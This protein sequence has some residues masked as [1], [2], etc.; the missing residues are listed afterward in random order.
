[1][2]KFAIISLILTLLIGI[3]ACNDELDPTA[4]W[5]N[6]PVVYGMLN[7]N[8]SVHYIKVNKAFLGDAPAAEMAAIS[9]SLFYDN[10][11]VYINQIE[12]GN[13]VKRLDFVP[14]DTIP[15]PEEDNP[16]EVEFATDRNT[17]YIYQGEIDAESNAGNDYTYELHVEIPDENTEC[18]SQLKLISGAY[19]ISPLSVQK[20]SLENYSFG[21]VSTEYRTGENGSLYQMVFRF[22]YLEVTDSGD[23]IKDLKPIEISWPVKTLSG[24]DQEV[25][26]DRS[27][28]QF[29]EELLI[30]VKEKEGVTR[31]VRYPNSATFSLYVADED[32]RIY[33]E[34]SEPSYGAVQEKPFFTNI[35]NGVGLFAARY[36]QER[37]I[38][39]TLS[40]VT[41]IATDTLTDQLNFADRDNPYYVSNR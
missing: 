2:K 25:S 28:E 15:K 18:T 14:V 21:S 24:A 12:S 7:Q 1:M 16:N 10:A 32:F 27:V 40:T 38:P 41:K 31:L 35:E 20:L 29:Y 22:Y 11:I 5:E 17:I 9:D 13:V 30:Q 36:T 8:D 3:S 6:I 39:V 26:L 33:S 4:E 19:I 34:I 23:T 37:T